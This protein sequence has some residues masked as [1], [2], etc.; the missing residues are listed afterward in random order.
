MENSKT[1]ENTN[2]NLNLNDLRI[3]YH[4]PSISI[5]VRI[6][7]WLN[8]KELKECPFEQFNLWMNQAL[9]VEKAVEPNAMA[10]A[11]VSDEGFPSLRYVL[12]KDV[13]EKQFFFYTNYES[14]K[15]SELSKNNKI[16]ATF[17]WPTL[18]RSV[19]VEGDA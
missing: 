10:I 15:A 14:R 12:L 3:E 1:N 16:A 4:T 19:R 6:I 5:N 8:L 18:N 17:Y 13:Y 7:Y 9:E 11:T 2:L